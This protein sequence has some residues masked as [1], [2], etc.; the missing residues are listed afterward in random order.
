M[1]NE[2]RTSSNLLEIKIKNIFKFRQEYHGQKLNN[3]S[4]F[5]KWK[6]RN[7]N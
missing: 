1:E 2:D 6:K 7:G 3:N 5:L 4:E